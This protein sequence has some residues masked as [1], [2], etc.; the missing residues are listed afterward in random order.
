VHANWRSITE[1]AM[2]PVPN[3]LRLVRL[4]Q[5]D[6]TDF[7]IEIPD[8]RTVTKPTRPAARMALRAIFASIDVTAG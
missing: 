3:M 7:R 5:Y 8:R 2:R 6:E 4:H 1:R